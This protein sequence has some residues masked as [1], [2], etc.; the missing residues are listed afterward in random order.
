MRRNIF[1]AIASL[2]PKK[3]NMATEINHIFVATSEVFCCHFAVN[4]NGVY[5]IPACVNLAK[6]LN[7]Q[8]YRHTE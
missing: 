2:S 6:C 7:R 5:P 3:H 1:P 4:K 8:F